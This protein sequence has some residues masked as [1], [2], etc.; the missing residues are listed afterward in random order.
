MDINITNL[1]KAELTAVLRACNII[2][3][4]GADTYLTDKQIKQI[5]SRIQELSM[6]EDCEL[7]K[8]IKKVKETK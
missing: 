3:N 7:T 8:Y 2:E 1:S 4:R 5:K 6:C